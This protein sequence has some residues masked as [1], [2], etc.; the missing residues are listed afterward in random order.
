MLQ[1]YRDLYWLSFLKTD[2]T[3]VDG[4]SHVII[5]GYP[6]IKRWWSQTETRFCEHTAWR[7]SDLI[8]W[9]RWCCC[10]E[11][12]VFW[13]CWYDTSAQL[14]EEKLWCPDRIPQ[15]SSVSI[16]VT[17]TEV[18]SQIHLETRVEKQKDD[19]INFVPESLAVL[20]NLCSELNDRGHL[21][22]LKDSTNIGNSW[23]ILDR[24]SLLSE[25]T[26]TIFA[27]E[28]FRQ[29][30]KLAS[31]TGVVP[32]SK[33]AARFP[34]HNLDMLVG[35]LSHLEFCHKISDPEVL[36]LILKEQTLTDTQGTGAT[37]GSRGHHRPETRVFQI[38]RDRCDWELPESARGTGSIQCVFWQEHNG[39]LLHMP[40]VCVMITLMLC[41][42]IMP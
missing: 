19:L 3:S 25:V 2:C 42:I 12:S 21:L 35:F 23:I 41:L 30:C 33:L 17:L 36:K 34:N 29:H 7:I 11:L 4:K 26:G 5:V 8:N 24:T 27:P 6:A 1:C 20:C 31:S 40:V 13:I 28:H 39:E 22:Y 38:L 15:L 10:N 37:T 16:A 18:Y 9:L 32:R 14:L